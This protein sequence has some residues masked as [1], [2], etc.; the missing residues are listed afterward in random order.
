[1]PAI[2]A[3]SLLMSCGDNGNVQV[4]VDDVISSY[5][6]Y[7]HDQSGRQSVIYNYDSGPDGAWFT[8]DDVINSYSSILYDLNGN[9]VGAIRY[10]SPGI[11][12]D[13]LTEDDQ[14][15]IMGYHIAEY[16]SAGNRTRFV[17]YDAGPDLIPLSAD[18][19]VISYN[20]YA[21]DENKRRL[22]SHSVFDPGPDGI[23][24]TDDDLISIDYDYSEY[25]ADGN[26]VRSLMYSAGDDG[27]FHTADDVLISYV[28]YENQIDGPYQISYD[29]QGPDGIWFTPDDLVS[30]YRMK[31]IDS[32]GNT[33]DVSYSGA[34]P[35]GAWVTSDDLVFY[36]SKYKYDDNGNMIFYGCCFDAGADRLWFT[37]D[38]EYSSIRMFAIYSYEYDSSGRPF[39]SIQRNAGA[40]GVMFTNDDVV[41]SY[42]TFSYDTNGR[43]IKQIHYTDPGPNGEWFK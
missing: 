39:R 13:W 17:Y 34:G 24:F 30:S 16:D 20:E 1:M 10:V 43:L 28:S 27:L 22:H 3:I 4:P 41:L 37:D 6:T 2:L 40:D 7:E 21:Y 5:S 29:G 15:D 9:L 31:K 38:D 14:T 12:G 35:D 33:L 23:W 42:T 18:D 11:D 19:E 25:D 8:G 26:I 32:D 36:Y